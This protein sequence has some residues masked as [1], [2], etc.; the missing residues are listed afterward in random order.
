MKQILK[1]FLF[2]LRQQIKQKSFIVTAIITFLMFFAATFATRFLAKEQSIM[3]P[4]EQN[5]IEELSEDEKQE[6][7]IYIAPDVNKSIIESLSSQYKLV[8]FKSEEE[9]ANAVKSKK[10]DKGLA[11]HT[12]LKAKYYTQNTGLGGFD[13]T[14]SNIIKTNY[15]YNIAL[16]EAGIDVNKLIE[17]DN[18]IPDIQYEAFGRNSF[19]GYGLSYLSLMFLYFMIL[20]FGQSIATNVAKEKSSRTMELLITNVKPKSLIIGK[21]FAGFV[22]SLLMMLIV[23]VALIIGLMINLGANAEVNEFIKYVLSQINASDII[24]LIV[25]G[26]IGVTMYYFVFASFGSLVSKIEELPQAL[27]PVTLAVVL[28][29]MVPMMSM[30]APDSTVMRIASLVPFTS[31]LA[32]PTR[33]LM[34]VVP[35]WEVLLSLGILILTTI[36]L[37]FLSVKIYRQGTLNYGNRLNFWKALTRSND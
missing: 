5:Q 2:E 8:E 3:P 26:L 17:I 14:I 32:M 6:M 16:P 23:A 27:S 4:T 9:L 25:F 10:H 1:V 33:Y 37:A 30:A 28:A 34:T 19:I 12:D 18:T 11:I 7:A 36:L 24:I 35:F 20:L 15:K 22:L 21:V 31:P 13:D 29:F